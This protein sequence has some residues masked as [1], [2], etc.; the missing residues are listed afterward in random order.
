MKNV[1]L[2]VDRMMVVI[3]QLQIYRGF[4]G[5]P[6]SAADIITT[7]SCQSVVNS[8]STGSKSSCKCGIILWNTQVN[9]RDNLLWQSDLELN[10]GP[11]C[12]IETKSSHFRDIGS[13]TAFFD[14]N[15]QRVQTKERRGVVN[16]LT[17]RRLQLHSRHPAVK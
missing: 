8:L 11:R 15:M 12:H 7:I 10:N 16:S 17:Y 4:W 2:N 6:T 3:K 9:I 14:E 13:G 1:V 5:W